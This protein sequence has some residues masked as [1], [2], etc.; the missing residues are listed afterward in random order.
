M[1]GETYF[2]SIKYVKI[3]TS[4]NKMTINLIVCLGK[5]EFVIFDDRDNPSKSNILIAHYPISN[6]NRLK[7]WVA[8]AIVIVI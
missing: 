2:S 6:Y 3:G 1:F 4:M 8:R 5:V 7:L